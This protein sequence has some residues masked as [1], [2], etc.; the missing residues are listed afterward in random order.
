MYLQHLALNTSRHSLHWNLRRPVNGPHIRIVCVITVK[1]FCVLKPSHLCGIAEVGQ[2]PA[3]WARCHQWTPSHIA[4]WP[5]TATS[6]ASRGLGTLH[7]CGLLRAPQGND[8]WRWFLPQLRVPRPRHWRV[9]EYFQ[10]HCHSFFLSFFYKLEHIA[11]GKE[12]EP[13]LGWGWGNF[14]FKFFN[15]F[16]FFWHIVKLASKQVS[17][18]K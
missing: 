1:P 16:G 8:Q 9:Q 5:H 15:F 7:L 12:G 4:Q 13:Q 3:T 18:E 11:C 6:T 14:F 2:T 17:K 10:N